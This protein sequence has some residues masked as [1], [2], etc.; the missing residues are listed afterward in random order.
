MINP[1]DRGLIPRTN[2]EQYVCFVQFNDRHNQAFLWCVGIN[3]TI[4]RCYSWQCSG[5]INFSLTKSSG[6][7]DTANVEKL[8][9]ECHDEKY[10]EYT[11]V[12]A[13][14]IFKD[15]RAVTDVLYLENIATVMKQEGKSHLSLLSRNNNHRIIYTRAHARRMPLYKL[16]IA[17]LLEKRMI[18]ILC[19]FIMEIEIEISAGLK[20]TV[21]RRPAKYNI[22]FIYYNT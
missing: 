7:L 4:A 13:L 19:L 8:I 5:V 6:K 12:C 2:F 10:L 11:Q 15:S 9:R 20:F 18:F 17:K 1:E 3:T 22:M 21:P 16:L 14:P